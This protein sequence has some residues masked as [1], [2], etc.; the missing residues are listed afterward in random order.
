VNTHDVFTHRKT[1]EYCVAVLVLYQKL[2]AVYVKN[3]KVESIITSWDRLHEMFQK[4]DLPL[5]KA[6]KSLKSHRSRNGASPRADEL[7][8][9][10]DKAANPQPQGEI[11]MAAKKPAAKKAPAKKPTAK[12]APAKKAPVA[13]AAPEKKEAPAKKESKGTSDD[14]EITVLTKENPK[15]ADA[16]RRFALYKTGMTV[17][18]YIEAGGYPADVRWDIKQG[19]IAVA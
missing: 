10:L 16:A 1:K 17:G 4:V 3:K 6:I 18:E 11:E 7:L 8:A 12:A 15:R 19:F 2:E 13:K 14:R 5:E 9:M